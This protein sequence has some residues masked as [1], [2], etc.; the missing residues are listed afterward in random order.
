MSSTRFSRKVTDDMSLNTN[1][2]AA[3]TFPPA[4]VMEAM[5]GSVHVREG[6]CV[7]AARIEGDIVGL[8]GGVGAPVIGSDTVHRH[9]PV[10][11]A[12]AQ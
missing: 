11:R 3:L 2:V 5:A 4:T 9:L 8:R 7:D 6:Q 1:N 10:R 12:L